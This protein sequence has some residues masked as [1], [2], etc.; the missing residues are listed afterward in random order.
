MD[1][2]GWAT[3]EK[4]IVGVA[5]EPPNDEPFTK[6]RV[7][8]AVMDRTELIICEAAEE[9]GYPAMKPEQLDVAVA[10]VDGCDHTQLSNEHLLTHPLKILI[11]ISIA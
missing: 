5:V 9:L 2:L 8:C 6:G 11:F 7:T 10:F 4:R 3:C 1:H